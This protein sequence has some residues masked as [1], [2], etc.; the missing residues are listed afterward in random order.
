MKLHDTL[1]MK[2]ILDG[3]RMRRIG[4]GRVGYVYDIHRG[5]AALSPGGLRSAGVEIPQRNPAASDA[6]CVSTARP[7]PEAP[8]TMQA[9]QSV[10]NMR[11]GHPVSQLGAG[12]FRLFRPADAGRSRSEVAT[13]T[14]GRSASGSPHRSSHRAPAASSS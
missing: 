4:A 1:T 8:P 14:R 9:T 12:G 13:P 7:I 10:N 6:I 11:R 5:S 3:R 2:Q